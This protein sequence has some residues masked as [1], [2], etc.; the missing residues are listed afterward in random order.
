MSISVFII[1]NPNFNFK[2]FTTNITESLQNII[3]Y[4][5]FTLKYVYVNIIIRELHE[6]IRK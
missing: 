6:F 5:D 3:K 2:F 1:L 4:D